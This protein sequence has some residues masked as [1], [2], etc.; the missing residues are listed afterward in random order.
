MRHPSF[1]LIQSVKKTVFSCSLFS[2][3]QYNKSNNNKKIRQ[4]RILLLSRQFSTS[5][6]PAGQG[7]TA[8]PHPCPGRLAHSAEAR[9][10]C[11]L[12]LQVNAVK[13]GMARG[14]YWVPYPCAYAKWAAF[15][16]HKNGYISVPLRVCEVGVLTTYHG[17]EASRWMISYVRMPNRTGHG[18]YSTIPV[19]RM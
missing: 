2:R 12:P 13:F 6:T 15:G 3:I 4:I 5:D 10:C 16:A 7:A 1:I 8:K 9:S 17:R 14:C 19:T 18:R 11:M